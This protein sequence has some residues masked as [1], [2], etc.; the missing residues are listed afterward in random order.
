MTRS[1]SEI[2][3]GHETPFVRQ[4]S[5]F[6]PNRVGQL[7]EVL[8][9]LGRSQIDVA[10]ISVIDSTDWAV[11]RMIFSDPDKGRE[12]LKRHGIAFT[13][14]GVLAIVLETAGTF[15]EVCKVLVGAE[16]SVAFAYSLLI[17]RNGRPVVAVHVDDE[18]FAT[19]A[20]V[21]HGFTLLDHEDL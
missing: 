5:L 9:L 20:L 18:V 4:F 14:C 12:I 19:Q 17:Q 3:R 11:V 6:L 21:K 7:Y 1:P 15:H 2:E 8:E 13:E 10:G 16:L